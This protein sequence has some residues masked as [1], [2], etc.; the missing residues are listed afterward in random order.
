MNKLRSESFPYA[1]EYINY[2]EVERSIALT[3]IKVNYSTLKKFV[4]FIEDGY[5]IDFDPAKI[6]INHIRRY[7]SYLKNDKGNSPSTRNTKL[8]VIKGY[9][10]FLDIYDYT[11]NKNNPAQFIKRA[12]TPKTLPVYLTLEE[13]VILLEAAVKMSSH[14][15]RD[16]AVFR[17]L[18]QTGCRIGELV[19]LKVW[20]LD[21]KEKYIRVTGK[22][23]KQRL[24]PLTPNTCQALE[25]Y[26]EVREKINNDEDSL[27]L[28]S[29]GIP[30]S[31]NIISETFKMLCLEA[32]IEK[33][34]LSLHKLRHTCLTLLL[35]A[36]VDLPVLKEIAGHERISTTVRYTHVT[37]GEIRQALKKHPFK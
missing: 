16:H 19:K 18:L 23:N 37:Q 5:S 9:F 27:F 6:K 7:L 34:N 26:M 30:L 14:P 25:K 15:Q 12:K 29:S 17:L 28:D 35:K 8:S 1:D 10:E 21:L 32:G 4:Q 3:T 24:I 20:D 36:G 33:P 13:S 31:R 2:L 22:G 11:N